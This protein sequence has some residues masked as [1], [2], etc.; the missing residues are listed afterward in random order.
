MTH[1]HILL[2]CLK[3][4]DLKKKKCII[5]ITTLYLLKGYTAQNLLKEFPFEMSKFFGSC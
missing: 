4:S 5:L 2:T 1:F 3:T